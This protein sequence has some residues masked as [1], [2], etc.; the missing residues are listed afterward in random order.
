VDNDGTRHLPRSEWFVTRHAMDR[1]IERFDPHTSLNQARKRLEAA[2]LA[3]Q[4]RRERSDKAGDTH[5]T[6]QS[7]PLLILVTRQVGGETRIVTVLG[8]A[9]ERAANLDAVR[10]ESL[11]QWKHDANRRVRRYKER[12]R[13]AERKYEEA[14]EENSRLRQGLSIAMEALLQ[15]ECFEEAASAIS[16]V[17]E[18][19]P[20]SEQPNHH[21]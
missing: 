12:R 10:D 8:S 16:A 18:V 5:W 11:R 9:E 3:A 20:E 2:A 13:E 19:I 21:G 14:L 7:D 4:R 17:R 15:M 1:Y 6:V